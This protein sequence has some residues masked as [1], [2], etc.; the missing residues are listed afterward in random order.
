VFEQWAE[1]RDDEKTIRLLE[2]F[3]RAMDDEYDQE[4][5][6]ASDYVLDL[7]GSH[8]N[9]VRLRQ[10]MEAVELDLEIGKVDEANERFNNH[11][12]VELGAGSTIIPA[13]DF[14]A[15]VDVFDHE[16]NAPLVE[17]SDPLGKFVGSEFSRDAFISFTGAYSRGKSWWLMEIAYQAV[18]QKRRAMLFEVGDMSK[19]QVM[20]R[21]GQRASRRPRKDQVVKYPVAFVSKEDGPII[22]E[23]EVGAV[24]ARNAYKAWRRMDQTGRFRLSVHSSGS[25]SA[26][27][28]ASIVQEG[29]RGGW[30]P[31][32][33][34]IDYV[35][36]LAPPKGISDKRDQI[37]ETWKMLRRIS[38]D[39][40]CLVVTATQGDTDSYRKDLIRGGNFSESRTKNDHI[41]AGFGINANDRDKDRGVFRLNWLKRRDDEFSE[42]WQI[43]V[44][45][46]L[47]IGCP[48]IVSCDE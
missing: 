19:R 7:A 47:A 16:K 44:A 10:T 42:N 1:K 31:D 15:W 5:P 39:M 14:E 3:L 45:G 30:I 33:I 13:K 48:C 25:L 9:T 34:V 23:R 24:S 20:M 8:F 6:L 28:V 32:V 40:H 17:F 4:S 12:K 2:T 46:C 43:A 37:D 22:K 26:A 35:D 21:M 41:T 36:L 29:E 38:Q 18:R 11:R 27:G